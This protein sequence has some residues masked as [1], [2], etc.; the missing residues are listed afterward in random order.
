MTAPEKSLI[1][2][3][4]RGATVDIEMIGRFVEHQQ[5]RP[6]MGRE[7][8]QQTRLFAARE[9]FSPLRPRRVRKPDRAD[10]ARTCASACIRHQ[11]THVIVGAL[12]AVSARRVDAGRNTPPSIGRPSPSCQPST[13]TGRSCSL[14]NVDLPLPLEPSRA[15]RSS[16]SMR[17]VRRRSTGWSAHSRLRHHQSQ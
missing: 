4:K 15:M 12:L 17:S 9:M 1:A 10:A 8:E 6:L 7:A 3:I 16:G 13:A 11:R 2:S 14:V 5:V